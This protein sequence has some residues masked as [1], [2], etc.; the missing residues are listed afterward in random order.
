MRSELPEAEVAV[1]A[2]EAGGTL[3]PPAGGGVEQPQDQL[4]RQPAIITLLARSV[5]QKQHCGDSDPDL[6]GYVLIWFK[7]LDPDLHLKC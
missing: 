2:D 4:H 7:I 6:H 5:T 1:E 3:P